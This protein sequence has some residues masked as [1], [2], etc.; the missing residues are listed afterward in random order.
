MRNISNTPIFDAEGI[1]DLGRTQFEDLWK[2]FGDIWSRG[3]LA[4]RYRSLSSDTTLSIQ[5]THVVANTLSNDVT[6]T[7]PL[8]NSWGSNKSVEFVIVKNGFGNTLTVSAQA[9]NSIVAGLVPSQTFVVDDSIVLVSD[10]V[11]AWYVVALN[12]GSNLA[13]QQNVLIGGDFTTNPWQR[14]TSFV[15]PASNS[16]TADRFKVSY[17]TSA[18]VTI[19]KTAD[20]SSSS[21]GGYHTE[22]CYD[23]DV[24]GADSSVAAADYFV[25]MQPIE[26]LVAAH[27]GFGKTSGPGYVTLV[28]DVKSTKT[29]TFCVALQNSAANRSYVAE[30]TVN[31]S[32]TWEKKTIRIPVDS[33]GT[34]LYDNGVGIYLYWTLMSGS[35]Y[36]GTA[37]TWGNTSIIATSNQVNALDSTSNNF[38]LSRV[39]LVAGKTSSDYPWRPV[40]LEWALCQRYLPAFNG[41][42]ALAVGHCYTS[43]N[44]L[45][46]YPFLVT[47][48]TAPTGITASTAANF[49]LWDG[50]GALV[51]CNSMAIY[52]GSSGERFCTLAPTTAGGLTVGRGTALLAQTSSQILFTGC[53]L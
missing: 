8:A 41:T 23:V 29:G 11:N 3:N 22:H 25:V 15:S 33:T 47:P 40:T 42:G 21:L 18:T 17:T 4:V 44:A 7:L 43:T 53:E 16:Y 38:K 49:S 10:G 1:P 13:N 51:A 6:L 37:N 36:Q 27:L 32:N 14:G 35:T 39:R 12:S 24:T 31:A 5:D 45:V 28:F 30:Y 9:T 20:S 50:A 26:G 46:D 34:W 52:G 19:N 48:R 2:K